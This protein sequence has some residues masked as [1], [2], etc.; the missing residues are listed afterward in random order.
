MLLA[1]IGM[2]FSAGCSVEIPFP[3]DFDFVF[4]QSDNMTTVTTDQTPIYTE[5]Y[6]FESVPEKNGS[7]A[8]SVIC[9][10][11]GAIFSA[12]YSFAGTH[13]LQEADIFFSWK[14][15]NETTWSDP[16][17]LVN[18]V[19]SAGN[20]VLYREG[21]TIW[22]FYAVI[23]FGWDTC[24]VEFQISTDRG[25]TW[26]DPKSIGTGFGLNVKYP[27]L[28]TGEG[29][30][31]LPV[32][33]ELADQTQF[34]ESSDGL[35]WSRLE[36]ISSV[37][38]N[39]QASVVQLSTGLLLAVARNT[40]RGH[41]WVMA[42]EDQGTSWTYPKDSLFS[43]PDSAAQLFKLSNGHLILIYNDSQTDRKTLAISLSAD[44]G[45]SWPY[46]KNLAQGDLTFSY[47]YTAQSP[48]ETI[49]IV[50][51]CGKEKIRHVALNEA[52]IVN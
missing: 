29:R 16:E 35:E 24:H 49:H 6:I 28:R 30:L 32:Y 33:N 46:K 47:P 21:E 11:D 34:Y 13:E 25:E 18:R 42:S 26:S 23:P 52:W 45:Q 1:L 4:N 37:P 27:P 31:L 12:W 3:A 17:I 8:S 7:H 9:F 15:P 43:N 10:D 36:K 19:Q 48:D 51:S 41:L 50:Y 38:G 2:I 20:P 40:K 5:E 22:L 14:L 44:E 39:I